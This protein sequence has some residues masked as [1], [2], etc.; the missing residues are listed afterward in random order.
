MIY[1]RLPLLLIFHVMAFAACHGQAKS[2]SKA[3]DNM[4]TTD[5]VD[6]A[7]NKAMEIAHGRFSAFDSAFESGK[8]DK[9]KFSIKVKYPHQHGNEYI[10]LV[11]IS[12]IKGHYRGIVSDTPRETKVVKYG[13]NPVINDND[14]VDWL[15]G[16]D[17]ILHGGYTLRL[18]YRRLSKEELKKERASFPYKIED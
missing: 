18:I 4:Y 16:K 1:N 2:D 6:T 17:S 10:W 14:V 7:M 15:Y 13:D 8:Y 3:A 11:N 12:K 5:A 9:D